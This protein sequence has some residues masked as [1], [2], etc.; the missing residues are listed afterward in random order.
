MDATT[1]DSMMITATSAM[2][3]HQC[4]LDGGPFPADEAVLHVATH[5]RLHHGGAPIAVAMTSACTA[6]IAAAA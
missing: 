5:N 2:T 1:G 4:D 6:D 3:C